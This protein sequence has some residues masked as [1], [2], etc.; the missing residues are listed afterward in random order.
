LDEALG[1]AMDEAEQKK[2]EG[3]TSEGNAKVDGFH[4]DPAAS[5]KGQHPGDLEC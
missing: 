3:K 1:E 5:R 4:S 2:G